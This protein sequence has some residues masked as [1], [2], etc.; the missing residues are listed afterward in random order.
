MLPTSRNLCSSA[1]TR[2][3]QATRSE[4]CPFEPGSCVLRGMSLLTLT[5]GVNERCP[6]IKFIPA[7]SHC[8][9]FN[10]RL[11]SWNVISRIASAH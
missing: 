3:S 4:G 7:N 5:G 9:P 11:S 6:G 2:L 8:P 10:P 1:L